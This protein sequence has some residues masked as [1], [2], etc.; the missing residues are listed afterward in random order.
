MMS[1]AI[2]P[3]YFMNKGFSLLETMVYLACSVLLSALAYQLLFAL[4]QKGYQRV[5]CSDAYVS[6][7]LALDR[8]HS[9]IKDIE[10]HGLRCIKR[11]KHVFIVRDIQELKDYGWTLKDARFILISGQF[12]TQNRSW[13]HRA[14]GVVL[15]NVVSVHF[16]FFGQR[17]KLVGVQLTITKGGEAKNCKL[18][19]F[20]AC[21]EVTHECM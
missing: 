17:A 15:D 7:A 4:Y 6:T 8:F 20:S 13:S 1:I 10:K 19:L 14:T 3:T 11:D 9:R 16:R 21:R 2:K 5:R 18:S 12:N